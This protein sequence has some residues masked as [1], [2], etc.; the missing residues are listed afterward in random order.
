MTREE[1][2]QIKAKEKELKELI[3][4]VGK[5]F[6]MGHKQCDLFFV[7]KDYFI[8]IGYLFYPA[9]NTIEYC[10]TIKY[11]D[12]DDI[13]WNVLDMSDNKK[14][15]LSLRA[16][17]AF[18]AFGAHLIPPYKI[19]S[20]GDNPERVLNNILF[21]VKQIVEDFDENLDERVLSEV[22]T[23]NCTTLE[24]IAYIHQKEYAKARKLAENCI[25][26]GDEGQF[27]NNGKTFFE[28]ALEYLNKNN[29]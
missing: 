29:L 3:K 19:V 1:R 12:Y 25:A 9:H 5:K 28:L 17:G 15:P 6:G 26:N 16:Y 22:K 7:H 20:L 8:T 11:L 14:E 13:Q 24:F 2:Q 18:S 27:G 23:D 4:K 10:V 21:E